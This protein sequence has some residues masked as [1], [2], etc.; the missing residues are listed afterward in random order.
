MIGNPA[1]SVSVH[2]GVVTPA[3][4]SAGLKMYICASASFSF[5]QWSPDRGRSISQLGRWKQLTAFTLAQDSLATCTS[6]H[7]VTA[8]YLR[9]H[10]SPGRAVAR[11][12]TKKKGR[13]FGFLDD[14][15]TVTADL[16]PRPM[17]RRFDL[18]DD[19]SRLFTRCVV[20]SFPARN[21]LKT[22]RH[23]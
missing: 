19:D 2:A 18:L 4:K 10:E 17:H 14:T 21:G 1:P 8:V 7:P 15:T 16:G 11:F 9:R 5:Q 6:L 3:R 20:K 23:F 12:T 13:S 22:R